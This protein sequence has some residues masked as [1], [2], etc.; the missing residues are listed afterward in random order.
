MLY[1]RPFLNAWPGPMPFHSPAPARAPGTARRPNRRAAGPAPFEAPSGTLPFGYRVIDARRPA[2][3]KFTSPYGL[4][5]AGEAACARVGDAPARASV[6]APRDGRGVLRFAADP[7][8]ESAP[9]RLAVRGPDGAEQEVVVTASAPAAVPL[10]VHAGVNRVELR[11]L[12]APAAGQGPPVL[13]VSKVRFEMADAAAAPETTSGA[14]ATG[15]G[16]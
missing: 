5:G 13:A 4:A 11:R 6:W 3:F 9:R 7:G 8:P 1:P 2:V 12:D 15:P 10:T 14:P 16:G